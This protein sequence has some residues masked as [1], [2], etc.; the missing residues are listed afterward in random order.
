MTKRL[1]SF[2][3][4]NEDSEDNEYDDIQEGK[5]MGG[6]CSFS[7]PN[8]TSDHVSRCSYPSAAEEMI[9]LGLK[10]KDDCMPYTPIA[11]LSC[12]ANNE[13]SQRKRKWEN[14]CSSSLPAKPNKR[15]N[16]NT[17]QKHMGSSNQKINDYSLINESLRIFVITWK[18]ACQRT[19]TDEVL[20]RM[21]QF[22]NTKKRNRV[23][24]LFTS[25][26][27]VGLLNVA[28]LF[29]AELAFCLL[30]LSLPD[31][32]DMGLLV[33]FYTHASGELS[34]LYYSSADYTSVNVE[35]AKKDVAISA[36]G[37]LMHKHD[38]CT[39]LAV[40]ILAVK[41]LLSLN[42]M[43]IFLSKK[44]NAY[45]GLRWSDVT[46]CISAEDIVNKI[47]GYFE[48]D[49]FNHRIPSQETKFLF[50]RKLCKCEY[51]LIEQYSIKEFES[52]G[53]GE[54]FMFLEKYMHM[55]PLSLQK[56]LMGDTRE[57]VY[58]VAH[59]LP[60][61]LDVLLSQ[62]LHSL[63]ENEI[64]NLQH[65]SELLARQ[66]PLVHF[67]LVKSDLM[68]NLADTLRETRFKLTS[69]CILFS[70][71]LLR[72]NCLGDSLAQNE[73]RMEE[74]CE[75]DINTGAKEGIISAVTAE[76]AIAV[77]LKAPM[78]IDL[79][80]WSHWD[81]SFAP[82]G[83]IV[84]FL[85]NEVNT[86]E[87]LCLVTKDGKVI[88]IDHSATTDSFLQVFIRGSAFET[89]LK[90]LSLFALYG[91]ER[92][93][94]LS[95]LKCHAQQAFE[96]IINNLLDMELHDDKN[97]LM[98]G[99][100]SCDQYMSEKNTPFNIGSKVPYGR[101]MLNKVVPVMSRFVLDCLSYLPIE[102]C[103][104][105]A[106]VL[107]SGLQSLIKDVPSAI[108]TEC[109]QIEQRLML[110]EV[111]ISLGIVEWVNDYRSFC[112]AATTGLS[113]GSSCLD[114]VK[115][116]LNARST[117][118]QD[119]LK[120]HPSSSGE[121]LVSSQAHCHDDNYKQISSGSDSAAI[122]LMVAML[123]QK[124]YQC[125]G[126]SDNGN[127][128]LEK[129]HARL[130]RALHCLSQELYSQ[131]S[132]FLLELVQNADDNV[133]P[134]NV[135]PTLTFIL[136]E[137]CIIVL[138]NEQG[139]S[140]NNIRALCD[141]GNSTKRV[142]D[143]PEVHSKGFHIK[144]DITKGQIGFVLPTVVPPCDIELYTRLA[145]GD[146][147]HINPN[148]WNTCIVLPFRSSFS[149][150]LAMNN[151]ISMFAD[152]HPSMLLFLHR[153]QCIKFRNMLDDSLI[154]MRKEVVGDGIVQV[155]L[156]S[157]KMTWF[158]ASQK[159][160]A[161]AVRSDVQ[162]TDIS[163][164]FTLQETGAGE[165]SPVLSEQPVFA[166]LPLRTYGLKFIVQGDF[167][168]PSSREEVDMDSPWNQ[169]LLSKFPD[170][171]VSAEGSFCDLPCYKRSPGKAV[172]AFM[173]FVPL[174]GE[175]HGEEKEWVPPCK[176]L[177]NWTD[178]TR[179]LLSDNLLHE[180]LGLGLLNKDIVL[181]E[182]LARALGV[183]EY[184]PKILLKVVSSL[185]RS[186]NGLKSMGLSWLCYWLSA[187][188]VM[189]SSHSPMQTS[190]SFG[191]E[192]DFIFKLQKMPIIP[193]S[194]SDGKYG[195]LNGD[196]IWLHCDA[197]NQ[198]V[199]GEFVLA[200]FPKLLAKLQTVSPGLLA[201][202]ASIENS[203]SDTT[204]LENV[205]RMLYKI[206]VQ[207]L[208]AHEILKAH[209]LPAISDAKN[210]IGQKELMIEYLSFAMFHLQSS[211]TT[212]SLERS[213]VIAELHEKALILTNHGYKRSNEVPI[214]FNREYGNTVDVDKL[215]SDLDVKWH[216]IDSTYLQ[217]PITK[218]VSGGVLKW[219]TF[220]QEI[221]VTDFVQ[222]VQVEKTV[223][224]MS[225][226]NLKY[227]TW[228]NGMVSMNSVARNWESEELFHLLSL[229]TTRNDVE[230]S[231]Y[232]LEIID[233]LWDDYFSDKATGYY[234][235]STG[236][237][238]PF[239]SSLISILQDVPW[240]SSNIDNELHYPKDL[241]H[242]CEA[243]NS[244]LSVNVP[245]TNPKVRSEKL[246]AD[247]C[248][249]TQ[250]TLDD[251]L[252]VLRAWR[253][254]ESSFRARF[255]L[256]VLKDLHITGKQRG[257]Q[258]IAVQVDQDK[259]VSSMSNFY[260]FLWKEMN[261]SKKKIKESLD[262]GPFIFVPCT[263]GCPYEDDVDGVLLSPKEVYWYDSTCS[264]D[265][266]NSVHPECGTVMANRP[267]REM[268]CN[269]YPKLHDFFVDECGVD[270]TPPFRSYLQILLQLS[271]IALPH[272]AAKKVF[273]VF[274]RWG[275]AL[276]SG[277][278]SLDDVEYLK[279]SLLK[280]EYAV[281][282][283]RQ[284]K[285]VSLHASFGL[286]CW[287]DD[288]S[289]GNEFKHA[290]GIDFLYF[291][292]F[293][294]EEN[295]TIQAKIVTRE[296]IYYGPADCN[297][298]VS[299]VNWVLSYAQRYMFNAYPDKYVQL[300]QS[301][302]EKIRHLK[303]VVVEKLFYRNVIEKSDI[304]SK[305]RHDCNC[306]LQENILYC[307]QGSNPHS[308]FLEFSRLLCDGIPVLHFANFLHMIT[309]MAESGATEE[310]TEFFIL[311][312]QKVPKLPAE[313]SL[314][315][316]QPPSLAEENC[317]P[318]KVNELNSL[319]FVRKS[320]IK[321]NWKPEDWKTAP[322][323]NSSNTPS[324]FG[325]K[326]VVNK[327]LEQTSIA[328]TKTVSELN[329]EAGPKI[330]TQG[331][332]LLDADISLAS[333]IVYRRQGEIVAFKYFSEKDGNVFVKWVNEANETGLPYDVI[334]GSDEVSR[335]YVEVKATKSERK[336]WFV[337]SMNEWQ[338]A[339]EKGESYSIAHV[340]FSND[341]NRARVTVYKNPA[342]LCQ[343]GNLKLAVLMPKQQ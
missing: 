169:W 67:K 222:I 72:L 88:R 312:S 330:I 315:S 337:I 13:H 200:A 271:A 229:L 307:K 176:V 317:P 178:Q 10:S 224:D 149:E 306:L 112:S 279:E 109:E 171:F 73:K 91:G 12:S 209:I 168:L 256:I 304:T 70:T 294:D 34:S 293:T 237:C 286:I 45:F 261:L 42:I 84:E 206:G 225:L 309:T 316:F 305:K 129:Q 270:E 193:L 325:L 214:H 121:K 113:R 64:I 187:M 16:S 339:I 179:F 334:I 66:F 31:I 173:S 68:E 59:L 150:A 35:P 76:D 189:M 227:I 333:G 114:F 5:N 138:N 220:L 165:L 79:K 23:K 32:S 278:L 263:S 318:Q 155:S 295:K 15:D 163:I 326:N 83:S 308:I 7:L 253:R 320:G 247:I 267:L 232:L 33:H 6:S 62:A 154:I 167:V 174:V 41:L 192:S 118:M 180:H 136:Q 298:I 110:H 143:A 284:D 287:C 77:F 100:P 43:I 21:L 130:G 124:S 297:F 131:D 341:S 217:H 319:K 98:H 194:V 281:L 51:W 151:I 313:E 249:K 142:T 105:A 343:L 300:K 97:A 184:G 205:T 134:Q 251:A 89:A 198:G 69:N 48:D 274:L 203:C 22:Y 147:S 228:D 230:K 207:R 11:D 14:T 332:V 38:S 90:L 258:K 234:V 264:I 329:I 182:S 1:F 283:T 335:E 323:F 277:S 50:L 25:Y 266:T 127:G 226:V 87:L 80:L 71:P 242:D 94:P 213:D 322:G 26:P 61:Q 201:A 2:A 56:G 164:A 141:V 208:S 246:V 162:T 181:S 199:N 186:D 132:H 125:E 158:L 126:L 221:G 160:H 93:V 236:E 65:V 260:T 152:L 212:C 137:K 288:D 241:F 111:G 106:N 238:K 204:V 99:K 215:I 252:S 63:W 148:A 3:Q 18:E 108:L 49:I 259:V 119:V 47:S 37:I 172:T 321:S 58:L 265:Q 30:K 95:L 116:D 36:Q 39:V 135:E 338:F 146:A 244:V 153:L 196:T 257:W 166:F 139:F 255:I 57:N 262:S 188:Y 276:K 303:I 170:L 53:H 177:R 273:E 156:G 296:A 327:S 24:A 324:A 117:I 280:K 78:M 183:E 299:L 233:R 17:Y 218:S 55:L 107:I 75:F 202:A 235:D 54:Y 82:L 197:A 291:G 28:I 86:K 254:S 231:K 210:A 175:A 133:Y 40:I 285:W 4:K 248:L 302:F 331:E 60:R 102:F 292:E 250:V 328:P 185:C 245:Y 195:S 101:G 128:M 92:N 275:D 140:A 340:V 85:L 243:V 239:K 9:R 190:A 272:Q 74:T 115:S 161:D 269:F 336:N 268:L 145:S 282:P 314:W 44:A 27:F 8:V 216:E 120:R 289:I 104:L 219:R 46:L 81:I 20:E 52:L 29:V 123:F 96:V 290:D 19:A 211:C 144:F 223:A 191:N 301:G 311:N 103:S 342:R 159:L 122:P 310:Q 240:I 157:E